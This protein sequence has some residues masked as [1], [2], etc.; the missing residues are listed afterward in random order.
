MIKFK[1]FSDFLLN[2]LSYRLYKINNYFFIDFIEL[3]YLIY[4]KLKFI[5]NTK[6]FTSINHIKKNYFILFSYQTNTKL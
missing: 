3:F 1:I 2:Y 4:Y 6:S 5:K